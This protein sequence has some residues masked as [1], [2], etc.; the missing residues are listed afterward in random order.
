MFYSQKKYFILLLLNTDSNGK[1]SK[2]FVPHLHWSL[3]ISTSVINK[4][5]QVSLTTYFTVDVVLAKIKK[6]VI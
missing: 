3:Y 6:K 2:V 1:Y 5:S 4:N